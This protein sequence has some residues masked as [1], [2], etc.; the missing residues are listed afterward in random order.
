LAQRG[1]IVTRESIRLWCNKFRSKYA[2][3]LRKRHQGYGD[4]FFIDEV[5]IKIYGKPS[6]I[7][8][9]DRASENVVYL[10]YSQKVTFAR[11]VSSTVTAV[12]ALN[13]MHTTLV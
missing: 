9:L 11:S 13:S 2:A 8:I 10:P 5:F 4:T 1:I 3:R 12:T 7:T 6:A